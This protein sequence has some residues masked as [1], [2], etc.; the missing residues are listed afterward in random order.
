MLNDTWD[1]WS[2]LYSRGNVQQFEAKPG[3][4]LPKLA[5]ANVLA[6]FEIMLTTTLL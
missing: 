5:T 1:S 6:A 2:A 3:K 4:H